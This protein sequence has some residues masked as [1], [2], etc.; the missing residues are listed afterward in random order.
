MTRTNVTD[1]D[2]G[3]LAGWFKLDAATEYTEN[4][5]WDGNNMVSLAT[6][7]WYEHEM[8]YRTA[9]GRWVLHHW[10]QWQGTSPTC[11]YITEAQ[12]LDWMMRNEYTEDDIAV[13]LGVEVEEERGPIGRPEIGPAFSVRFP[14]D[15]L[16]QVDAAARAAQM[17]RAGWLRMVAQRALMVA[18][19]VS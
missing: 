15:L 16:E 5:R 10:S 6:G 2:T 3:E 9:A 18:S 19:S 17:T 13:A 12:A 8:L 14:T 4:K 7:A 1:P 11:H